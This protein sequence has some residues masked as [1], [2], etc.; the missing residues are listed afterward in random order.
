[1][2]PDQV[3]SLAPLDVLFE[4]AQGVA[5]PL[6]PVLEQSYGQLSFALTENKPHV[7]ANFVETIDGVVSLGIPGKAGGGP[8]SGSNRHD[9]LVMGLLRSVA[10]VVVVGAGTLRSVPNHIWTPDYIFPDLAGEFAKVRTQLGKTPHA[11]NV[12]ITGSGQL[13]PDSAIFKQRAVPVHVLTTPS[14]AIEVERRLP[15]VENSIATQG[16]TIAATD[17][18]RALARLDMAHVV[19]V[20]SGPQLTA[21]FLAEGVLDELF[22]T[23]APQIAGRDDSSKRP[24]L[25][26][27]HLFAPDDPRWSKLV[28]VRRA[29]SH[30]F[31]R[32]ALQY[33]DR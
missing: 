11:L 18:I 27:G 23:F 6:S 28:S 9:R 8:I 20:E 1:M 21:A 25:I 12:F 13:D 19:L 17:I 7:I 32:Y 29:D 22:L 4:S 16:H 3:K 33:D 30:L 31:L 15:H 14:G 26:S 24:G 5:I 10:D 2:R